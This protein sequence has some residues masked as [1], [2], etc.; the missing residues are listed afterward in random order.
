MIACQPWANCI[1]SCGDSSTGN[2]SIPTNPGKPR[3]FRIAK[4]LAKSGNSYGN[5]S[6]TPEIAIE[7]P[8]TIT[9]QKIIFCPALNFFA[10]GW[11]LPMMPPNWRSQVM[12]LRFGILC[13]THI[14]KI[15]TSPMMNAQATLLWIHLDAFSKVAF[16]SRPR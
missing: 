4:V 14:T 6:D 12:S 7:V 8:K 16:T 2:G 9:D 3:S 10:G 15:I 11:S 1:S 5:S 13:T